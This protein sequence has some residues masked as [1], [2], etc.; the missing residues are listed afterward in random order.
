MIEVGT[1]GSMGPDALEPGTPVAVLELASDE[2]SVRLIGLG[3]AIA[4]VRVPDASG[5]FGD[6]HLGLPDLAAYADRSRNPHFGASI[7]RVANRISG[8]GFHLDG[9][10]YD[11]PTNNG[12]NTLHGGPDGWDRHVWEL[13]DAN[14]DDAGGTAVFGISSPDGDQGF[15]GRVTATATFAVQHDTLR[16]HYSAT[17]D[18]ATVLNMTNH[19]YWNLDGGGGV[20]SHRVTLAADQVLPVDDAGIPTGGLVAVDATAFDLRDPTVL[21]PA[22]TRVPGGFDH[23]FAIRGTPGE[24]RPTAL[25]EAPETGRWMAV[26][27]D[28]PGVQLYTG[29]NLTA[30]FEVHGSV[31]LETQAFPDTPNRA[32]LGSIRLDPGATYHNI[33]EYRFGAGSAR[34]LGQIT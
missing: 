11:L 30:P 32:E 18:A 28:Q 7:G 6:V 1:A 13:L 12:V 8:A 34:Q 20:A 14:G 33:T 4:G 2:L 10:R 17:T 3:A 24:L 21:G 26:A 15:P 31:S 23:C 16:I 22:M 19:G 9:Q 27:T 29:N 5:E 25:L